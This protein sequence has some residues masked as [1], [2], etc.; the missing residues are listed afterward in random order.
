MTI[1]F[2]RSKI[3]LFLGTV[4]KTGHINLI[5][6]RFHKDTDAKEIDKIFKLIK[7]ALTL[8]YGDG[9]E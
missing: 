1:K 4:K 3:R 2:D 7:A 8:K 6:V 5:G 9:I